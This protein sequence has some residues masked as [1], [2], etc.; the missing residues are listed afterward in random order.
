MRAAP[1]FAALPVPERPNAVPRVL[2]ERME[3]PEFLLHEFPIVDDS[4][5]EKQAD[6]ENY[7]WTCYKMSS[8]TTSRKIHRKTPIHLM[9]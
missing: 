3:E 8:Q 2:Q 7:L 6:Q 5:L 1:P 4:G 9:R